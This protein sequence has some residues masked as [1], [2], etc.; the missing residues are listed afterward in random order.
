MGEVFSRREAVAA[1]RLTEYELKKWYRPIFR[2]VYVPK[3]IEPTLR[4]RTTGAWLSSNKQGVIA[5]VAASALH[6]ANWV[7]A[8]VPIE[9]VSRNVRRQ[10]G[11]IVRNETLAD[12]EITRIAKLPVTTRVR[13]A[14]DLGRHLR[15]DEALVRLD[16]L[17]RSM[18]FSTEDV[19]LLIKRYQRAR[20]VRQLREL[21]PLVDGGAA[22]PQ[23]SLLRLAFLDN[24]LPRPT[25]Q[26][27]VADRRGYLVRILDMAWE[28]FKVA[29][30]YDGEQHQTD[31]Y[32]YRKDARVLPQ[33]ARMGWIVVRAF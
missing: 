3:G 17:M 9:L 1:G 7:P 31:R 28:E 15:R 13:T 16:A 32:Q 24:G 20:G 12:D 26:H 5:G 18:L 23:E 11:L 19:L 30:E 8:D 14:F 29:A 2:G 10:R 4:D 22:S 21:L 25:T 27:P 33:L 6:G